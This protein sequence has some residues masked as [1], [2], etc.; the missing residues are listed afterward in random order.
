MSVYTMTWLSSVYY[1]T[2]YIILCYITHI[3]TC[4]YL[5]II[6]LYTTIYTYHISYTYIFILYIYT[7]LIICTDPL[8]EPRGPL[9]SGSHTLLYSTY[10]RLP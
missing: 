3:Y 1:N 4:I 5:S 2:V 10:R 8:P 6:T 7:A 9:T